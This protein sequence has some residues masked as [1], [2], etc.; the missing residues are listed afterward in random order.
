MFLFT[1]RQTWDIVTLKILYDSMILWNG[2]LN[3]IIVD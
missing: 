3:I 1:E 2:S